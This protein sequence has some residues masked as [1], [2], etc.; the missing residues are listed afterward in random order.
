M[1]CKNTDIIAENDQLIGMYVVSGTLNFAVMATCT[2]VTVNVLKACLY[3]YSP[4]YMFAKLF[5]LTKGSLV[6]HHVEQ[7]KIGRRETT[8]RV[9]CSSRRRDLL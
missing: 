7:L 6:C 4:I 8:K 5:C 1:Q 9:R 2:F 3:Y